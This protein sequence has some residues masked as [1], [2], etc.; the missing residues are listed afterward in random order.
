VQSS[1]G[2][3]IPI[4]GSVDDIALQK[5]MERVRALAKDPVFLANADIADN[6]Q[7]KAIFF[8]L[9]ESQLTPA[10]SSNTGPAVG[11][12]NLRT[13]SGEIK[14]VLSITLPKNASNST[15]VH[16]LVHTARQ[17]SIKTSSN[18]KFDLFL[19][20]STTPKFD[21][22]YWAVFLRE[23]SIAHWTTG[24]IMVTGVGK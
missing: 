7:A 9:I 19:Y 10:L 15:I 4:P 3:H 12:L 6:P 23:E 8:D 22:D 18:G 14:T 21:P 20:E 16:E 24:Q 17:A 13:A 1:Y 11:I 5:V 2:H